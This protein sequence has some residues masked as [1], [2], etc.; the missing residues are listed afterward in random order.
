MVHFENL[1]S[2][3]CSLVLTTLSFAVSH[4]IQP[5]PSGHRFKLTPKGEQIQTA[6]E[7]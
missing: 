1:T 7:I 6:A 2:H 4:S 3:V 5:F